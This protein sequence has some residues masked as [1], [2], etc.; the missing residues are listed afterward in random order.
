MAI[1]KRNFKLHHAAIRTLIERQ[2][3]SLE[4]AMLEGIMNSV[5]AGASRVDVTLDR[6]SFSI[7]DDGKGFNSLDQIN[8]FFDTF[9]FPHEDGDARYGKFRMGRGQMFVFAKT[10]WNTGPFEMNVDLSDNGDGYDLNDEP[11]SGGFK[12]CKIHGELFDALSPSD[13]LSTERNLIEMIKYVDVP[14]YINGEKRS[15]AMKKGWTDAST[16]I[17]LNRNH[18]KL[19]GFANNTQPQI[20][21]IGQ[22]LL[23]EMCHSESSAGDTHSH[24]PDFFN[25]F[26]DYSLNT[27]ALSRF[28]MAT[29]QDYARRLARSG[30]KLNAEERRLIDDVDENAGGLDEDTTERQVVVMPENYD[31]DVTEDAVPSM[32]MEMTEETPPTKKFNLDLRTIG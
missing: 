24:G 20:L 14:I 29:Y 22:I 28:Y 6:N 21:K 30:M 27:N 18:L 23:H 10:R 4:K 8:D 7:K 1:Q 17:W 9:G 2:A 11:E 26:H 15:Q 3:G 32:P 13:F 25:D 12:G 19:K 5:D 31:P 16:T